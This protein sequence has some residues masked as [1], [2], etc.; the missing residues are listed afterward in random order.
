[1]GFKR[2]VAK[3]Q[4]ARGA[5]PDLIIKT[6]KE[7]Y[8]DWEGRVNELNDDEKNEFIVDFNNAVSGA[9]D[10]VAGDKSDFEMAET[11]WN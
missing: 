10:A 11:D 2:L 1:M 4:H 9:G 7:N 6:L 8:N 3:V 5:G